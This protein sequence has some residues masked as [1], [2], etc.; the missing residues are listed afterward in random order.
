MKEIILPQI[1]SVGIFNSQLSRKYQTQTISKNRKTT[2]F[3]LELP[4]S[5]S[6]ISFIDNEVCPITEN[7]VICVKPGS[8]RRTRLPFTCY[9]I[10]IVVTK[11]RIYDLLSSLPNFVKLVDNKDIKNIFS[12]LYDLYISGTENDDILIQSLILKLV[13]LLNNASHSLTKTIK[14]SNNLQIIE[15]TLTYINNHL[16]EELSLE[17]LAEMANFSATYF[18]KLFKTATRKR[19]HAYIEEQRIKKA[20]N[21]LIST[22]MTLTQIAYEC[23]FSSQSYFSYAFKRHMKT[24]PRQYV[25]SLAVQYNE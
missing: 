5:N 17:K 12:S 19:L 14:T 8:T 9:Y 4:L 18:H 3:E 24:T 22:N 25:Q 2:M 7:T 13:Y 6:G 11:G 21:L 16:Y 1:I 23:G 10:H 15:D 20:I